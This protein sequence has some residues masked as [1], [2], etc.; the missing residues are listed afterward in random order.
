MIKTIIFVSLAIYYFIILYNRLPE[1]HSNSTIWVSA[2]LVD[3]YDPWV[4]NNAAHYTHD[5]RLGP[6]LVDLLMLPIPKWMPLAEK[7]PY[8]IGYRNLADNLRA[9][10]YKDDA[11]KVESKI[12]ELV[13]GHRAVMTFVTT[14]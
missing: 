6:W 8:Y 9:N 2:S 14:K 11:D 10:G 7:S 4:L 1:W 3:H 5:K 13:I 12:T